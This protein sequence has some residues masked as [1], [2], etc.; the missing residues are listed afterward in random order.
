MAA[1]SILL[2]GSS[3]LEM[4]QTYE[5][6]VSASDGDDVTS[7]S[8]FTFKILSTSVSDPYALVSSVDAYPNPVISQA[9]IKYVLRTDSRVSVKIFNF[10]GQE[11][12]TLRSEEQLKGEYNI[13]WNA[14]DVASGVY[15]YEIMMQ[16]NDGMEGSFVGKLIK[17]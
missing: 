7:T 13:S 10:M 4:D 3:L 9:M 11:V 8:P 14:N 5:W 15:F 12:V 2:N 17:Q 16:T 6:F 1:T